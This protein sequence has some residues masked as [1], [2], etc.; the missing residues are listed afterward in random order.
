MQFFDSHAHYNDEC[1]K[2]NR[3]EIIQKIYDEGITRIIC[4]GYNIVSSKEAIEIAKCNNFIYSTS[5]ISPNDIEGIKK[6]D[7]E[8]I[9]NLAQM[10]KNVAIGEIGLDYY[11][12][13]EN[14]EEQKEAFIKQIDIANN[15]DL[16]IVIHT[17][18]AISDTI[19]ILKNKITCK[20]KGVFHCCPHNIELIKEGLKLGYYISFAG[21]ITFKNAKNA[22]TVIKE[23][24]LERLL[25]ETDSPYLSPEPLR[26]KINDS[27]NIKYIAEKIAK[28]KEITLE[29]VAKETYQNTLNIFKL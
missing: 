21:S 16:P 3:N 5:G 6:E 23:V 24:P 20:R 19:D 22:E 12:N 25:I 1:F 10:N 11:W 2:D 9:F 28:V 8:E 14:K 15:L 18:D 4:A 26:G 13:K 27:R 17:R 7:F 29:Q